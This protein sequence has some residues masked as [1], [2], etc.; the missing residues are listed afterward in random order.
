M[1]KV[2]VSVLKGSLML[3]VF[4]KAVKVSQSTLF[5]AVGRNN[6]NNILIV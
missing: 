1:M 5:P 6:T 3:T 2:R 4:G